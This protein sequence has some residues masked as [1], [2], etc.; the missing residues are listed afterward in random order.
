MAVMPKNYREFT[1][2]HSLL[3]SKLWSKYFGDGPYIC[4]RSYCSIDLLSLFCKIQLLPCYFFNSSVTE[5]LIEEAEK[6]AVISSYKTPVSATSLA[7]CMKVDSCYIPE[8]VPFML[9]S[10]SIG[11]LQLAVVN[12]FDSIGQ[13]MVIFN[14]RVF[15]CHLI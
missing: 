3:A 2:F 6:M 7:A 11:S 4:L 12:S 8:K 13:G 14:S 15:K 5:D 9:A 10:I 1:L